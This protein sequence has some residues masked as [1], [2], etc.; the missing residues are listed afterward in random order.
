[1]IDLFA[2]FHLPIHQIR[3][4]ARQHKIYPQIH[5]H[6]RRDREN[7]RVSESKRKI[8]ILENAICI[9]HAHTHIL[10]NKHKEKSELLKRYK[11]L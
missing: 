7:G 5:T 8:S 10:T 11:P 4:C 6:T 2:V 3:F 1:M 9:D